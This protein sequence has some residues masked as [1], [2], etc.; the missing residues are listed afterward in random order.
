MDTKKVKEIRRKLSEMNN[1]IAKGINRCPNCRGTK[2]KILS[3][4]NNR[5]VGARFSRFN[6]RT[7]YYYTAN[8]VCL[9]RKCKTKFS[10]EECRG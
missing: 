5:F 3:E 7:I 10:T 8:R 6:T 9:N 2:N 4:T 1:D